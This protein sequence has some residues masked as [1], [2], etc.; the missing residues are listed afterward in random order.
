MNLFLDLLALFSSFPLFARFKAKLLGLFLLLAT[1]FFAQN[2]PADSNVLYPGASVDLMIGLSPWQEDFTIQSLIDT[3]KNYQLLREKLEITQEENQK[4]YQYKLTLMVLEEGEFKIPIRLL[5]N[6]KDTISSDTLSLKV[7]ALPIEDPKKLADIQPIRSIE[8]NW[9]DTGAEIWQWLKDNPWV[10]GLFLL[11]LLAILL[12]FF[13]KN[14]KQVKVVEVQKAFVLPEIEALELLQ[15][16]KAK[17]IWQQGDYKNYYTQLS[18]ILRNYLQ[19]KYLIPALEETTPQILQY[20]KKTHF[21]KNQKE[22]L[23]ELLQVSDLVKFAKAEPPAAENEKAWEAIF[24]F[25][26][27]ENIA[28]AEKNETK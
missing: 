25:I 9:K 8:K 1:P 16:L 17:E 28:I 15:Q 22:K 19:R 6:Q 7:Q 14:R 26:Q 3:S 4:K 10:F 5:V 18:F 23:R 2:A 20:L 27:Q 12:Y 13:L 11:L 24:D 21:D